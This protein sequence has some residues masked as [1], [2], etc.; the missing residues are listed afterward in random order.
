M[1]QRLSN[2]SQSAAASHWCHEWALP[3]R[4][5]CTW[6]S[7]TGQTDRHTLLDSSAWPVLVS[8][9]PALASGMAARVLQLFLTGRQLSAT[10]TL[11]D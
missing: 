7:E 10:F 1:H 5:S 9:A 4:A 6:G 2:L 8:L 11:A 3:L